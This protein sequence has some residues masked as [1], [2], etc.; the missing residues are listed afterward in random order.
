[1]NAIDGAGEIVQRLLRN[2]P[3][4]Q[5]I[6][7]MHSRIR[8]LHIHQIANAFHVRLS[9][10]NPQVAHENIFDNDGRCTRGPELDCVRAAR[11]D[12]GDR[13]RS[14]WRRGQSRLVF[15][16]QPLTALPL[17]RTRASIVFPARPSAVP[18]IL[19]SA[20]FCAFR[21]N[22]CESARPALSRNSAAYQGN[23]AEQKKG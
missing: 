12:P 18:P 2:T 5:L 14:M 4:I 11:R 23:T 10:E 21:C 9:G 19:I 17:D 20:E 16:L 22:T 15:Q 1:M 13:R 8:W 7:A 3:S 6:E